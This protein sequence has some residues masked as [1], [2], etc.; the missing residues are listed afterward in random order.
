MNGASDFQALLPSTGPKSELQIPLRPEP[1]T[2]FHG[3]GTWNPPANGTESNAGLN[4]QPISTMFVLQR[5]EEIEFLS[6]T[7]TYH[8]DD[9][10]CRYS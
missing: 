7:V 8:F 10:N 2:S 1:G 6:L 4:L 5:R 3:C 9:Q